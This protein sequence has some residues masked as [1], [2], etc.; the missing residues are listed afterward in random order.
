[1]KNKQKLRQ[2]GK[3]L[4]KDNAFRDCDKYI[5]KNILKLN[6]YNS[7]QN[8]MLFYPLENE[9]DLLSLTATKNKVFSMPKIVENEI[10]PYICGNKF[11]CGMFNIMEPDQTELQDIQKLDLV[12]TPALCADLA[13]NRI[14][15]GKGYYDRFIKNLD[16]EKT[17]ILTVIPE[18]C[19]VDEI[20][21]DCFDE[22]VDIIVTE[23]RTIS[24]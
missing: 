4:R 15:Y 18:I 2:W 19:L 11:K 21:C 3:K 14:G 9:I 10:V 24:L 8:V 1:M 17:K 20:E 16:R 7:S 22:R 13:G 23:K 12:I 5:I 6:V